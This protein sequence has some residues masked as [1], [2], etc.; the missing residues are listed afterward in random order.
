MAWPCYIITRTH[1]AYRT[2]R[3]Y[4]MSHGSP[5]CPAFTH[6]VGHNAYSLLDE[7]DYPFSD[8]GDGFVNSVPHNHVRWPKRC[9][10]GYLFQIQDEWQVNRELIWEGR[11][12]KELIR[13]TFTHRPNVQS[14]RPGAIRIFD[15]DDD[16]AGLQT[17][18]K[19]GPDGKIL[20][21]LLPGGH[22]WYPDGP[23]Q[24]R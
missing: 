18:G 9:T 20:A 21:I 2:L 3:R 22:I 17:D 13:G 6:G 8:D 4:T 15:G 5:Q 1:R 16:Y 10:C 11:I 12:G 24:G 14:L 19:A 23:A 7:V